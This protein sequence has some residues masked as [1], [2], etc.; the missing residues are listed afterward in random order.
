MGMFDSFPKYKQNLNCKKCK[1]PHDVNDIYCSK[2]GN[3]LR[4][5]DNDLKENN[6]TEKNINDVYNNY[7]NSG[8]K[9]ISEVGSKIVNTHIDNE[10]GSLPENSTPIIISSL[11]SGY[12]LRKTEEFIF[13]KKLEKQIKNIKKINKSISSNTGQILKLTSE[14]I[15][16]HKFIEYSSKKFIYKHL[17]S[18]ITDNVKYMIPLLSKVYTGKEYI[19]IAGLPHFYKT[20]ITFND[21]L[22]KN[23]TE[24]IAQD[25]IFGYCIA[26]AETLHKQKYDN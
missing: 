9:L 6:L 19:S 1:K 7:Y 23:W 2:C 21:K 14:L 12:A 3:K 22:Q 24:L 25:T 13:S 11:R 15:E 16:N 10:Y 8:N 26:L 4:L 5:S 18:L 20:E 17:E